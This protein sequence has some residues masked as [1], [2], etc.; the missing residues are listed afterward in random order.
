VEILSGDEVSKADARVPGL[1]QLASSSFA[2]LRS[3]NP[4]QQRVVEF[5]R[6]ESMRLDSHELSAL[7]TAAAADPF[8]KVKKLIQ[9]LIDRLMTQATNEASHK[10]WC[11]KELGT[12]KHTRETKS[13]EV[14]N[15]RATIDGLTADI[16]S[17]AKDIDKKTKEVAKIEANVAEFTKK[18]QKEK[19]ENEK[20][21]EEAKD[22]Q[23]AIAQAIKVLQEFYAKAAKAKALVQTSISTQKGQPEIPEI[24]DG[25]FKGSQAAQGGVV[26]MLEVIQSDF[27]RLEADTD[28][29]EKAAQSEYDEFMSD[30]AQTKA[31]LDVDLKHAT[32]NKMAKEGEL[33]MAKENLETAEKILDSA[34]KTWEKLKEPCANEGLGA[35]Q[36]YAERRARRKDEIESLKN[37]L[38]ILSADNLPQ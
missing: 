10:G 28:S 14:E 11:D 25:A 30:S 4:K 20:A 3:S 17:L 19:A 23:V 32:T 27:A 24:F 37:A 33:T 26:G 15:L 21:I 29:S 2:Q 7:A 16:S 31:A 5:L 1:V 38:E 8:V 35:G 18:R 12:N 34:M 36:S 6:T 22:G 13:A 9:E